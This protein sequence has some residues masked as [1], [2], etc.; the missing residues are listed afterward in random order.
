MRISLTRTDLGDVAFHSDKNVEY[1][2]ADKSGEQLVVRFWQ[3]GDAFRPLGM[4]NFRKLSDFF[5]DLKVSKLLKKE[6]PI[7]CC[8]DR[9][10]WVAGYRIDDAYKVTPS[11][12][13]VLRLKLEKLNAE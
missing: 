9:I 10:I 13:R 1:I 8:E 2:D 11:T 4:R 12:T 5:I 7:V 6:I 3:K